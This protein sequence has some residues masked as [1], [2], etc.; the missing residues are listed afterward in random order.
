MLHYH[1]DEK[2]KERVAINCENHR[3][4]FKVIDLIL[5]VSSL[6]IKNLKHPVYRKEKTV[7]D[8]ALEYPNI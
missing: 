6:H 8:Q 1:T 2:V 7:E 3:W 5:A 4:A